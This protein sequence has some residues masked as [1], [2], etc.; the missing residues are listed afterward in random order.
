MINLPKIPKKIKV[1]NTYQ[2][3]K[4]SFGQFSCRI[5]IT[6]VTISPFVA[7]PLVRA[8]FQYGNR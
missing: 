3:K 1:L 2:V 4:T 7:T 5:S 8:H 6:S